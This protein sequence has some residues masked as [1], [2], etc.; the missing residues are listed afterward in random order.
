MERCKCTAKAISIRYSRW[1]VLKIW[2]MLQVSESGFS[3]SVDFK[4]NSVLPLTPFLASVVGM[5]PE[6]HSSSSHL[7][8]RRK[9]HTQFLSSSSM[10]DLIQEMEHALWKDL[11]LLSFLLCECMCSK[12]MFYK[13]NFQLLSIY[14]WMYTF[15]VHNTTSTFRAFMFC[16]LQNLVFWS[17]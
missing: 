15:G 13:T 7:V 9:F 12:Y 4:H 11:W 6:H 1:K 16:L 17:L 14:F 2:F 3:G 5:V 8:K 10:K